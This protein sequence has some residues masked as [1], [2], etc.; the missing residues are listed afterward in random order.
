MDTTISCV[1]LRRQKISLVL[2]SCIHYQLA[3]LHNFLAYLRICIV[4]NRTSP[5][6]F[7]YPIYIRINFSHVSNNVQNSVLVNKFI[8]LRIKYLREKKFKNWK[9]CFYCYSNT[10]INIFQVSDVVQ[11]PVF[12]IQIHTNYVIGKINV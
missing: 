10:K 1:E 11:I 9:T 3:M 12:V 8:Q 7:Y 5:I 2:L 4:G 6:N